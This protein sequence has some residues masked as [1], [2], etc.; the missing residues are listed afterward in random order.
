MLIR[1]AAVGLIALFGLAA[2][3]QSEEGKKRSNDINMKILGEKYVRL[4]L[5]DPEAAEFRN[6]FTGKAGLP[7]GEVNAK[8]GFGAYMGFQRYMVANQE[9]TALESD[10]APGEFDISWDRFCK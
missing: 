10:M 4:K 5:K 7:C 8:N 3:G 9:M 1:F 2:C 6:Q